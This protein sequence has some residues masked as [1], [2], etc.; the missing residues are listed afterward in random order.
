DVV[1]ADASDGGIDAVAQRIAADAGIREIPPYDHPLTIAGQ[2]TCAYEAL[3]QQLP[4]PVAYIVCPIGGGGLTSGTALA[5]DAAQSTA[6]L[7]GVEPEGADDTFQSWRAGHRIA[8]SEI[9]TVADALLAEIPGEITFAINRQKLSDVLT[10][11]DDQILSAMRVFWQ[12]MKQVVEPS[13][14]V[15]LAGTLRNLLPDEGSVLVIVS[16]GNVDIPEALTYG[17]RTTPL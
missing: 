11:T 2:A 14:A 4:K 7:V 17:A 6:K 1:F 10:V 16:G 13:G 5:I 15:S 9:D 12:R 8:N 3:T